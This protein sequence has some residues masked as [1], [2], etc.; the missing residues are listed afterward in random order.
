M[1]VGKT[2]VAELLSARMGAV[3]ISVREALINVLR[4]GPDGMD[5]RT[6]QE[7]GARLDRRTQGRWLAEFLLERMES[8]NGLVVDSIRT[9]KQCLPILDQISDSALVYLDGSIE[10]RRKRFVEA[11]LLDPVKRSMPFDRASRYVTEEEVVQLK[12]I[13]SLVIATD[14]LTSSEV[15]NEVISTLGIEG[16]D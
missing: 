7:Q 5:R 11:S 4:L 1:G 3:R 12:P 10:T 15:V 6:L 14:S 8:E 2:T 9:S 16:G 13:A